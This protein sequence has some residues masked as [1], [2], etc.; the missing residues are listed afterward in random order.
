MSIHSEISVM[1]LAGSSG[2]LVEVVTGET[3]TPMVPSTPPK[4]RL[5]GLTS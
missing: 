1:L 2:K 4:A 3:L 5:F